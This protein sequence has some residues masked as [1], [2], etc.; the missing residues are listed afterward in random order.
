MILL[1]ALLGVVLPVA[2]L[3]ASG[4][5]SQF[6]YGFTRP[7]DTPLHYDE[8]ARWL[9]WGLSIGLVVAAITSL[10]ATH[11]VGPHTW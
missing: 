1:W 6:L 9:S 5:I 10:I 11:T 8:A 7:L 4:W 2:L 3:L